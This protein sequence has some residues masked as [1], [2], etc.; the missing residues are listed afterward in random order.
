MYRETYILCTSGKPWEVWCQSVLHTQHVQYDAEGES[1]SICLY[2]YIYLS[3]PFACA[4]R[5]RWEFTCLSTKSES[6]PGRKAAQPQTSRPPCMHVP[7]SYS[8]KGPHSP[9]FFML[10][11]CV[12]YS[13][14]PG[15]YLAAAQPRLLLRNAPAPL[16]IGACACARL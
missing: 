8:A 1:C 6:C 7:V 10:T 5:L 9:V 4:T 3:S 11:T 15:H 16:W 2:I 14:R 12:S 13:N